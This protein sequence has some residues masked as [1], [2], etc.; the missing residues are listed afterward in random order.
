VRSFS[1]VY[2]SRGIATWADEPASLPSTCAL[3]VNVSGG[4]ISAA[5]G[6]FWAGTTVVIDN[7]A[8]DMKLPSLACTTKCVPYEWNESVRQ[9]ITDHDMP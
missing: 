1:D 9:P 3:A 2:F 4:L 7:R 5:L 6:A 8:I